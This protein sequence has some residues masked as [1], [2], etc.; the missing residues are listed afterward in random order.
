M[1]LMLD[2]GV[3][4][5]LTTR[6]EAARLG[7]ALTA[8]DRSQ[9]LVLSDTGTPIPLRD[10]A[11]PHKGTVPAY[12]AFPLPGGEPWP[13]GTPTLTTGPQAAGTTVG[14]LNLNPL[15]QSELNTALDTSKMAVVA[16]PNRNYAVEF[17]PRY[18]RNHVR[19]GASP[20]SAGSSHGS[21]T[22]APASTSTATSP[23]QSMPQVNPTI[24]GIPVSD[25]ERWAKQGSSKL[26]QWTTIGVNDLAD[27]LNLGNSK[28]TS[29]KHKPD[30]G[31]QVLAPSLAEESSTSA[32][33]PVPVP[34]PSTWLF[35]GLVLGV[36]GLRQWVTAPGKPAPARRPPSRCRPPR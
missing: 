7:T 5:S 22:T 24:D 2:L 29:A 19:L 9:P 32:T 35:F 27:S 31:A 30:L 13:R 10:W 14:P 6:C 26:V 17:L 8:H 28:A 23:S 15:I 21:Q 36:A 11:Q 12:L 16:T 4:L 33:L 18:A 34:E 3:G 25:L 1:V 20:S